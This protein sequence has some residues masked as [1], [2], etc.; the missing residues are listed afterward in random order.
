MP[1]VTT[2]KERATNDLQQE[3]RGLVSGSGGVA[4]LRPGIA[5]LQRFA[6]KGGWDGL[7]LHLRQRAVIPAGRQVLH[8]G[9]FVKVQHLAEGVVGSRNLKPTTGNDG[10]VLRLRGERSHFAGAANVV[11]V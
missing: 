5:W 8:V 3:T 11:T 7:R 1:L 6:D 9:D 10:L 4:G 2:P